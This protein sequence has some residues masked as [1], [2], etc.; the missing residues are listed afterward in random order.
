MSDK[1]F[2][3]LTFLF[4]SILISYTTFLTIDYI[5]NS[6]QLGEFYTPN[7]QKES[8]DK[9]INVMKLEDE[10]LYT[11]EWN[12]TWGGFSDEQSRR[13]AV[14][15][16]NNIYLC[17]YTSSF[18]AGGSDAFL[19]K[20][21]SL[22][23]QL[24][25]RT[26]GGTLN[27]EGFGL[28]VDRNNN[29]Y[30]CGQTG[31]FGVGSLDAFLIKYNSSGYQI[32]N[33]TWGGVNWDSFTDVVVDGNNNI[34]V[35]GY[36]DSFGASD[37]D[38]ILI[39]YNMTG[40][41][42]W[43]ITWGGS[44][45]D[46]GNSLAVDGDNN[47]YL[48]GYTHIS[49]G[50]SDAFLAKFDTLGNQ[51]WNIT[52]GG[53]FVEHGNDVITDG[54][55]DVYLCGTSDS[56]SGGSFDA[57]L[58][59]FDSLGNQ[60]WNITWGGSTTDRGRGVGV[61]GNNNVY[62]TG[63]T[64]SFGAGKLDTFLTMYNSTGYQMWNITWGGSNDDYG[65]RVAV[66]GLN[67]IYVCGFTSSF[68]VGL[69]DTFI[70]K[71]EVCYYPFYTYS[72]EYQFWGGPSRESGHG[73]EVDGNNNIYITG[74][75][76]SYGMGQ[77]DAFLVKYD[78]KS[79]LL[80]NVTWGGTLFDF[81]LDVAVDRNNYIYICGVIRIFGPNP[82]A[83]L[84]KYNSSGHEIWN[85][86]W[87][88]I[89]YDSSRCVEVD[90]NNNVYICGTTRSY[91]AGS[92]DAFIVK[93]D[94]FG[95]Q[96]WNRTWGG[97][98]SD[99][100]NAIIIDGQNNVILCGETSSFGTGSSDAFIVKYD[101]LGN[102]IYNRTWGGAGS[103]G[104]NAISIDVNNNI[105]LCGNTN[106]FG[107]LIDVFLVKYDSMGTL[108]WN[109]T[110]G[111]PDNDN[112]MSTIVDNSQNV[113]IAGLCDLA[114][115]GS[116][117]GSAFLVKYDSAGSFLWQS[118]WGGPEYEIMND[119]AI[120][121]N[122]NVYTTGQ[123]DIFGPS[124]PESFLGKYLLRDSFDINSPLDWVNKST[125]TVIGKFYIEQYGINTSSVQY[126]YSTTGSLYPDN[127]TPV[128]GV[129][130]DSNCT[131]PAED[132]DTGWLYAKV[133]NVPFNQ[134]SESN[135]TIRF[136]ATDLTSNRGTQSNASIIKIDSNSPNI[137]I[138]S[139]SGNYY[140]SPPTMD[141][142]FSDKLLNAAYYRIDSY[143]PTGT[144]TT[145]WTT[146][147][148]GYSGDNYT[149]NF[150][151]SAS[152]WN[153][154]TEGNHTVYFKSWDDVLNINGGSTPSW[155]F[156]KDIEGP[157][158]TINTPSGKYY[159]SPPIIDVD[160][161]DIYMLDAA[162]YKIDSFFPTGFN[163]TGWTTIF[164]GYSG[165]NYTTDFA[166]TASIWN[167]LNEGSHVIYFKTW[168][169]SLNLNDTLSITW[170][171]Y[172]D[173]NIDSPTNLIIAPSGFAFLNSFDIT[174]TNPSDLSGISGVYY[175]FNTAPTT[176]TDGIFIEGSNISQIA[177]IRVSGAGR[178]TIY[179]WMKDSA[180]NINYN[181]Y[182]IAELK[183][184]PIEFI[185]LIIFSVAAIGISIVIIFIYM[186]SKQKT[187]K[188][189]VKNKSSK[190]N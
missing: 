124:N 42:V 172:K 187:Q 136:R 165:N 14:D 139:P 119:I 3:L 78:S 34:Y 33:T 19:V 178:H 127:W 72:S 80:W 8:K 52:W 87:G 63:D 70:I 162:Y 43:N 117:N 85:K 83:F 137:I 174:W 17:G 67:S 135:N 28:V 153:S 169:K 68:G 186:G 27:D 66:D 39:K 111:G 190:K 24:W 107:G 105:Y 157:K 44:D 168:D 99:Y 10:N 138:N 79:N 71:Y 75:T 176:D 141:V 132:G 38:A 142:D 189:K 140:A 96:I 21:D 88:G 120:D 61:D 12:I 134:D 171:F 30:F 102:Q 110:W 177:G 130:E 37:N 129:Y 11:N 159:N 57:F 69:F 22:G 163:T 166:I 121:G 95:N 77:A 23:N 1:K 150:P 146:I 55:N 164:S 5:K 151:M 156:Y 62:F 179:I 160:F 84:A 101:S 182:A 2:Q 91:G 31:S 161:T 56:F 158:F 112:G 89:I 32:W 131:D 35:S 20:Y 82:A 155:Q 123:T 49:L 118:I 122:N 81:S 64:D 45:F 126:A 106:S 65:Y 143:F 94:S 59:K 41:L 149:S 53:S 25:N 73:I 184:Y 98:S 175:K 125:P 46:T 152:I 60:I 167:S 109:Q 48:C 116:S 47:L 133:V 29:I 9:I 145:G 154:L 90:W 104:S 16:L 170:Q 115:N 15:G 144:N 51:L 74:E 185:F 4:V 183:Y 7:S 114:A 108:I 86:T 54:N 128:N 180:G 97:N 181:N 148:S 188:N 92:S 147:F 18:G 93:Y 6:N 13:I 103:E 36:T 100:G 173:T 113:Y 26:W 58:A 76:I 50:N 40:A